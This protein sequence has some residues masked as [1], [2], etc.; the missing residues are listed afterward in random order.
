T[1]SVTDATGAVIGNAVLSATNTDTGVVTRSRSSG[2]GEFLVGFLVPGKYRVEAEKP[3]FQRYVET[4]VPVNAG[5]IA[6]IDFALRVGEV[7]QQVEVQANQLNVD[8]ETSELS[9]TFSH[10]QL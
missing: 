4:D 1:G 3:G 7:L 9:Q 2:S 6:R 8:T 5:G 10:K